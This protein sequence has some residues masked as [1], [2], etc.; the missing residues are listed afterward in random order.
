LT[1]FFDLEEINFKILNI[2]ENNI[3]SVQL[4]KV[5]CLL[6]RVNWRLHLLE[7]ETFYC[8][9]LNPAKVKFGL[10]QADLVPKL[11]IYHG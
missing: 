6:A 7:R 5:A 11:D 4:T 2:S 8:P 10:R 9:L 1:T 3:M